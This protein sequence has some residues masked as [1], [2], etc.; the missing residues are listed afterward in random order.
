MQAAKRAQRKR[1]NKKFCVLFFGVF[2]INQQ[3]R[4]IQNVR[5]R[6]WSATRRE[7]SHWK[8]K[9]SERSELS[10]GVDLLLRAAPCS[11]TRRVVDFK[12]TRH[13][14]DSHHVWWELIKAI[15][16][17]FLHREVETKRKQKQIPDNLI[18][19]FVCY[20][21]IKW[22]RIKKKAVSRWKHKFRWSSF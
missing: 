1:E 14:S 19:K 20:C 10:F 16:R 17:F 11:P 12:Y 2:E 15:L 13:K 18:R 3:K 8:W 21:A 6:R 7:S 22:R 4:S 5:M 9:L